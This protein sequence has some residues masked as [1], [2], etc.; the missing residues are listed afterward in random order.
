MRE[1]PSLS[2]VEHRVDRRNGD[3]IDLYPGGVQFESQSG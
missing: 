3:A 2:F 1:T